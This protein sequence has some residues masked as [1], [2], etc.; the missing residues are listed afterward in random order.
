M[1]TL[2]TFA[3]ASLLL[4]LAQT[5]NAAH[6]GTD[7]D[8]GMMH[9]HSWQD[10][11]ANKDGAITRDEFV[12]SHKTRSDDMFTK[13]D[14]NKDGTI[15]RDEF[16]SRHEARVEKM[17]TKLDANKD[18]KIDASEQKTMQDKCDRHMMRK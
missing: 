8:M 3:I 4:G 15:S 2:H 18:G 13:L 16:T 10:A 12:A 1:K 5:A 11:D 7:H 14:T 6:D 9:H 17:F